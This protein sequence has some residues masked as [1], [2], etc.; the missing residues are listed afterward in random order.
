MLASV[1][2]CILHKIVESMV[3]SKSCFAKKEEHI[4]KIQKGQ[5]G[6]CFNRSSNRL[7]I[8]RSTATIDAVGR[9]SADNRHIKSASAVGLPTVTH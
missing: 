9:Q 6:T 7:I 1:S 4:Q 8:C 2:M 3:Y 5:F